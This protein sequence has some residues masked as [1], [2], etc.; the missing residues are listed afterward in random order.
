MQNV[1]KIDA[2]DSACTCFT[3]ANNISSLLNLSEVS[4]RQ[5]LS[6]R[7]PQWVYHQTLKVVF[8]SV[9]VVK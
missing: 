2:I 4:M 8:G 7:H 6:D 3:Y 9:P 5:D 1:T